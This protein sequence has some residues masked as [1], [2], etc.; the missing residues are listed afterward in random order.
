VI[1]VAEDNE[2]NREVIARQLRLLS[3]SAD[4]A[5]DGRQALELWRLHDY[6]VLL[7][8]LRMPE[9]DGY[10]LAAAIRAG[11]SPGKRL[12]I[13]ALT[14]NALPEEAEHCRAAGFD[15]Y[16]TKPLLLETLRLALEKWLPADPGYASV[17][18]SVLRSMI[19][20]DEAEIARMLKT[21]RSGS[22]Q[23]RMELKRAAVDDDRAAAAS[24]AHRFKSNAYSIGAKRLGDLCAQIEQAETAPDIGA[25]GDLVRSMDVEAA[26]VDTYLKTLLHK[27]A[28]VST[29]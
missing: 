18:L 25:L 11:E 3:C 17:D 9:M 13:I 29:S 12:P 21:F 26:T 14:A 4:F 5:S 27:R 16:L 2:M 1:L 28:K 10:A 6:V 7:S 23:L 24:A 22:R 19:G 8:D 15:D 20:D